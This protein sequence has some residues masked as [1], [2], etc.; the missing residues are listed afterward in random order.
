M[1]D[2][3]RK[4]PDTDYDPPHSLASWTAMD[5]DM[6]FDT[7]KELLKSKTVWGVLLL[8]LNNTVLKN[9]PL[10]ESF[11]EQATTALTGAL[12][13]IGAVIAVWGRLTAKGPII[14]KPS[15]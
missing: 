10:D 14:G 3:P 1:S 11:G 8:L 4:S 7:V 6:T 2:L 9:S 15:V 12:D 13:A 5:A